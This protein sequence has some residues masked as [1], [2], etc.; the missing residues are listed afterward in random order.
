MPSVKLRHA[1]EN[2]DVLLRRWKRAVDDADTIRIARDKEFYE[3]PTAVRK[4]KKAAAKKRVQRETLSQQH[5]K[6]LY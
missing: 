4:R 5:Q 2:F 6:R 1:N 3:K